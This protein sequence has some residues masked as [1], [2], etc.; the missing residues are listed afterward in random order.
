MQ[1]SCLQPSSLHGRKTQ[2]FLTVCVCDA[3][4]FPARPWRAE[5]AQWAI[6]PLIRLV[7]PSCCVHVRVCA[8]RVF[9]GCTLLGC[10]SPRIRT[11]NMRLTWEGAVSSAAPEPFP[12]DAGVT[13]SGTCS[14]VGDRIPGAGWLHPPEVYWQGSFNSVGT[15]KPTRTYSNLTVRCSVRMEAWDG[16]GLQYSITV[17][18]HDEVT[19]W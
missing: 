7:A 15:W 6:F 17:M 2:R 16:L 19:S 10:V 14:G 5:H 18:M 13:G 4:H 9:G 12:A 11:H 3:L 8:V 1:E